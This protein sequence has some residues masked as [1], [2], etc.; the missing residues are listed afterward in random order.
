MEEFSKPFDKEI[1]SCGLKIKRFKIKP[2]NP[3][4]IKNLDSSNYQ[5]NMFQPI[6]EL[7]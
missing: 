6:S 3:I 2:L 5:L 7:Y 4:K 1:A